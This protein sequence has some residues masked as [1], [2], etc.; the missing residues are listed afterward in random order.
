MTIE[1]NK[2]SVIQ[3]IFGIPATGVPADVESWSFDGTVLTVELEKIR[4]LSEKGGA[5]RFEGRGL[6]DRVL[7]VN[8]DD[9]QFHAFSNRCKHMGRRLDPVPGTGTVQCCSVNKTTY[10]YTGKPV[11]GP[12]RGPVKT[13]PVTAEDGKLMIRF[14]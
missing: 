2:R 13:Y 5:A 1:S 7:I 14:S 8:G 12:A 6:P 4:Q 10:D 3:R 9:G 11:F